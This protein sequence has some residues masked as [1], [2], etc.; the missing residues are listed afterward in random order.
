M[1]CVGFDT[2]AIVVSFIN[3]SWEQCHVSIGNFE[4]HN[5]A[6]VAMAN[7]VRLLLNSFALLDKVIAYIKDERSNL[8]TLTFPLAF[9]VSYFALQLTCPFV[10][11]CFGHAMS[12]A[13]Q[14]VTKD[15][16]FY[17]GFSYINLK[18][19]QFAL[20]KTIIWTKKSSKG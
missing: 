17:V 19:A 2:I 5:T 1:S 12:K 10:G 14:Y 20:E 16:E 11:S 9:V 4:V 3:V 18:E 7:R 13:T 8:N 15:N 6:S